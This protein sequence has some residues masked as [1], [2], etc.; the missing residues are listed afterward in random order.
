M[1]LKTHISQVTR[2]LLELEI[3]SRIQRGSSKQ[4][5]Y[6]NIDKPMS[7]YSKPASPV[8][9]LFLIRIGNIP[10]LKFI[11]TRNRK[12]M[13]HFK[14]LFFISTE[15]HLIQECFYLIYLIK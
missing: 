9:Q 8:A 11:I 5:T 3:L 4:G 10:K 15:S 6:T 12:I 13:L 7:A 1:E 14:L 2:S